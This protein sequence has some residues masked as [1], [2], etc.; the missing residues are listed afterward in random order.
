[1]LLIPPPGGQ[2]SAASWS[3]EFRM[4]P[5]ALGPRRP[6]LSPPWGGCF[7]TDHTIFAFHT[8]SASVQFIFLLASPL[9]PVSAADTRHP[10][11][12]VSGRCAGAF[13]F[14]G[15]VGEGMCMGK[16]ERL[17]VRHPMIR[18]HGLA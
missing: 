1:M 11:S 3:G 16:G 13:A 4:C 2:P 17:S 18:S 9:L 15:G 10:F 12:V 7:D 14:L 5:H 6:G 8:L